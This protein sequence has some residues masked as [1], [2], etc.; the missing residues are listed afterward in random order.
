MKKVRIPLYLNQNGHPCCQLTNEE[1]QM[2]LD[3]QEA[4]RLLESETKPG[5]EYALSS[6]STIF[7]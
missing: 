7:I 2:L 5:G 3:F 1:M 4:A 6:G